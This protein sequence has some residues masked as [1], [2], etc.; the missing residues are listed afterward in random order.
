MDLTDV[1][2]RAMAGRV[3]LL[4]VVPDGAHA[5]VKVGGLAVDGA[6]GPLTWRRLQTV[7]GSPADG[8]PGPVTY[9]ALQS[10]LNSH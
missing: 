8:I 10:Y 6:P 9:R 4:A 3:S 5:I 2:P 7:V 1:P